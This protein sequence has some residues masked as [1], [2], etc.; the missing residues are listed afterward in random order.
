[1]AALRLIDI[2]RLRYVARASRYD[3]ALLAATTLA[4][5]LIGVE[6]AI[7]IGVAVS[8]LLFVPRAAKLRV[9]ELVV[10][11]ERVV[12]ERLQSDEECTAISIYD[13]EGEL[14]FGA[15]PTL[16]SCLEEARDRANLQGN[17]HLVF[18]FKRLRNPD[19]VCLEKLEH[20]LR[21]SLKS[22][23]VV[24]LAGIRPDLLQAMIRLQFTDWFPENRIFVEEDDADSATLKA[25]RHA[26]TLLGDENSCS[27][28]STRI[29]ARSEPRAAYYLV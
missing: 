28:C 10:S 20:F 27:H 3:A 26:Y 13:F 21:E 2:E 14:F 18:R 22:E 24:I 29:P 5:L 11:D 17:Q 6:F 7:L 23:L 19:A 12:R 4:A 15:A 16:E 9:S 25:V 8:L 1:M